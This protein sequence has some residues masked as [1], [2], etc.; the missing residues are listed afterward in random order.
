MCIRDS[1]QLMN[2][3]AER[4]ERAGLTLNKREDYRTPQPQDPMKAS[5]AGKE[6]WVDDHMQWVDRRA[7]VNPDG[8][9]MS[10]DQLRSMLEESWRSIA[11]DGA[12]KR[13]KDSPARGGS[14]LVGNSKNA[15]RQLFFKDS[16][17]WSQAMQKL[18]LI[19]I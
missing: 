4:F 5:A 1:K 15:P 11:T 13:G 17:A 18:S 3:V 6:A 16:D 12:N 2:T 14:A 10:D 7:Y 8:T 19:H 9:R